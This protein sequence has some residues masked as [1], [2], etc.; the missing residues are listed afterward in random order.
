M[1]YFVIRPTAWHDPGL[2][3]GALARSEPFV[4]LEAAEKWVSEHKSD[5]EWQIVSG[6]DVLEALGAAVGLAIPL[7][8]REAF[9]RADQ[10]PPQLPPGSAGMAGEF[11][12][13]A[14]EVLDA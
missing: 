9:E 5:E 6:E 3:V 1:P 4:T 10:P 13:H 2:S 8:A 12:E 11:S 14:G 7:E